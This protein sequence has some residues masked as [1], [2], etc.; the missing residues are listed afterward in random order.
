MKHPLLPSLACAARAAVM[1]ALLAAAP[2]P[3]ASGKSL[4]A[5]PEKHLESAS[6]NASAPG[7]PPA[8]PAVQD[9]FRKLQ[10]EM[11]RDANSSAAASPADTGRPE[12]TRALGSVVIQIILGLGL[13]LVLAVATIRVLKRMQGRLLKGSGKGAKGGELFEVMETCHLGAHQRVVALRM[14]GEVG[15]LGVTQHGITLLTMLNGPAE[16]IRS[17]RDGEGNAAAFSDSLNKLLERF[18]KPKKV[19]DLIDEHQA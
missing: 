4:Y 11:R 19:S 7:N 5:E 15:V 10:N 8:S 6:G 16:D 12:G 18:K 1:A 3:A 2:S 9:K 17:S 13:V 14:N